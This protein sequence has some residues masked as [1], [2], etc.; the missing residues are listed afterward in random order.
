MS[1]FSSFNLAAGFNQVPS[2]LNAEENEMAA[3]FMATL[4]DAQEDVLH[5]NTLINRGVDNWDGSS[6]PVAMTN[7]KSA[8]WMKMTAN[9]EVMNEPRTRQHSPS[10]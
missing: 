6:V 3:E 4:K 2:H 8:A 7:A 1:K 10:A 5:L 9:V